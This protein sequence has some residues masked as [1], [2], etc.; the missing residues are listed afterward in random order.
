MKK[1]IVAVF[2]L[3]LIASA[4]ATP[5]KASEWGC[6]V[7]LCTA[8]PTSWRSVPDCQPPMQKLIACLAAWSPCSWPTCPEG[9]SNEGP[10]YEK[11]AEC[12]TGWTPDSNRS[13]GD[14]GWSGGE[15]DS[16]SKTT[17]SCSDNGSVIFGGRDCSNQTVYMSRPLKAEPYYW[18]IKS[19]SAGTTERVFFEIND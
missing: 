10:G 5:A 12:P 9:N 4:F 11:Y 18:D 6:K 17:N 19:D 2:G 1:L 8:S 13:N 15:L 3:I 16:C 14:H 7:L